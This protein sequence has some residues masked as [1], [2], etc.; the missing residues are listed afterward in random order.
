[1]LQPTPAQR[2]L[3]VLL[4]CGAPL[5]FAADPVPDAVAIPGSHAPSLGPGEALLLDPGSM[6]QAPSLRAVLDARL[7]PIGPVVARL[8]GR[9]LSLD[10]LKRRGAA[11]LG[12][13][14]A[15]RP[16]LG[17]D[18]LRDETVRVL[19]SLIDNELLLR[20]CAAAGIRPRSGTGVR[21]TAELAQRLGGQEQLDI[22]LRWHGLSRR[23]LLIQAAE[24]HAIATWARTVVKPGIHVDEGEAEQFYEEHIEL[25]RSP[26]KVRAAHILVRAGEKATE[27]AKHEAR[28]KAEGLVRQ[29]KSG[30]DFAELARRHSQCTTAPRGGDLGRFGRGELP[31]PF[32]RVAFSLAPG[33]VSDI[34]ETPYGFHIVRVLGREGTSALPFKDVEERVR[35]RLIE[36]KLRA[37]IAERLE[38]ARAQA[39][40]EICM[41]QP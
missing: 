18:T 5:T 26:E 10:W 15:Q 40:V 1:M 11:Q 29:L 21:E 36:Q 38:Q 28:R 41:E 7:A 34:V 4:L 32:E 39:T 20:L 19:R 13:A 24:E 23:D 6:E 17:E 12:A 22:V 16:D 35:T 14:I 2:V 27:P 3:L 25:Y 31:A 8:D 30:A 9:D 33:G 37:A